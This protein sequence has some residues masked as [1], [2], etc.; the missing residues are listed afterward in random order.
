M[1]ILFHSGTFN[2]AALEP[3]IVNTTERV[4]NR[5]GPLDRDCYLEDE[6]KLKTLKWEFGFRYSMKNC[7]YAALLDKILQNCSCEPDF[8]REPDKDKPMCR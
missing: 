2:L 4:I 6:F 7:L 3:E 8:H 5:F 1:T